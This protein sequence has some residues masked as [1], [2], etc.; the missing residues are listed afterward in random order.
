MKNRAR[1]SVTQIILVS[2]LLLGGGL[3]FYGI[4]NQSLWLDELASWEK[5]AK[6]DMQSVLTEV[7]KDVHPPGYQLLLFFV[8]RHVGD[9]EWHLRLPSAVAGTVAIYLI[10]LIGSWLYTKQEGLT[11]AALLATSWAPLYYSQ[12]ARAYSLLLC[13]GLGS[14]YLGLLLLQR[15]RSGETPPWYLSGAYV[16]TAACLCYLHYFGALLVGLEAIWFGVFS[17]TAKRAFRYFGIIFFCIFVLYSPWIPT[18][19]TRLEGGDVGLPAPTPEAAKNYLSFLFNWSPWYLY[20]II[21]PLLI[22][23][24][25]TVTVSFFRQNDHHRYTDLLSS[26]GFFLLLWFLVPFV[27]TYVVSLGWAPV[28]T[29]RN[30]IIALP[31]AYL[32]VARAVSSLPLKTIF[33]ALISCVLIGCSLYIVIYQLD[34]YTSPHKQQWREAAAYIVDFETETKNRFPV[35]TFAY[36]ASHLT[37]YFQKKISDKKVSASFGAKEDIQRLEKFIKDYNNSPFWYVII[38]RRPDHEFI[39]Y[40]A[41]NFYVLTHKELYEADV[42]LVQKK[43]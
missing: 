35:V 13:F 14:V 43:R 42:Y 24:S 2:I 11:A 41:D 40:L 6:P 26:P 12:E 36:N 4:S 31:P 28:F 25:I 10:Y 18:I 34:Y 29:N 17:L 3:R 23:F 20:F 37:Y 30:L 5:S 16:V 7:R 33:K 38:H 9:A 15:F 21:T 19:F 8:E 32:L 1:I 39:A 22:I 27:I